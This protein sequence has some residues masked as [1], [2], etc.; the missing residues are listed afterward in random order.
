M[1]T[2][3]VTPADHDAG[4]KE[5]EIV[6][7]NGRRENLKLTAPNYRRAQQLA[8]KLSHSKDPLCIT[9]GCLP[10]EHQKDTETFLSRLTP[11][12][13][14][15]VEAIS[16]ALTFGSEFQKKM[17]AA[18]EKLLQAMASTDS[19]P[20]SPLSPPDILPGKSE[21]SPSPSCESTSNSPVNDK[22]NTISDA[23]LSPVAAG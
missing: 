18:G 17:Q 20:S 21:D 23:S 13:G 15:V 12:S 7:R 3:L 8:M 2:E 10:K 22:S 1:N 9:E 5:I 16:F 11:E 14:S 4:F 19:A 6:Y